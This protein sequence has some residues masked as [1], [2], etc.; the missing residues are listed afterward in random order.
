MKLRKTMALAAALLALTLGVAQGL[1]AQEVGKP[2]PDF[3]L[4]FINGKQAKLSDYRGKT[5]VVHFWATWCPPCVRELPLVDKM[6]RERTDIVVLAV[7]C[8]EAK[9]DVAA[10]L[11]KKGLTLNSGLDESGDISQRYGIQAIPQTFVVDKDGVVVFAKLGAM[12]ESE[13]LVAL[14]KAK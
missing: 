6:A 11:K 3:T 7:E 10:F 14:K 4:S 12:E 2:A 5:V 9:A 1:G 13:Y 8:G